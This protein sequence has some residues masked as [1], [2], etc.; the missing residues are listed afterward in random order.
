MDCTKFKKGDLAQLTGLPSEFSA[1]N[2]ESV[3]VDC[4]MG[5]YSSANGYVCTINNADDMFYSVRT[6]T[7]IFL[8]V[9]ESNL[10]EHNII[11]LYKIGDA[12]QIVDDS[13]EEYVG[14]RGKITQIEYAS[15]EQ[16][17]PTADG[18]FLYTVQFTFEHSLVAVESALCPV[19]TLLDPLILW[20]NQS[21][22]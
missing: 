3:I 7:P 17:A 21:S 15:I 6:P 14:A 2:G 4:I 5:R 1:Y 22:M 13:L 19:S 11:P 9:A 8:I 10:L 20:L 18:M 16:R 12:V